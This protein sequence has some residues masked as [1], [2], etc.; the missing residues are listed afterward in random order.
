[1]A[2]TELVGLAD[3]SDFAVAY[4]EASLEL[5]VGL[6]AIGLLQLTRVL[7]YKLVKIH[8]ASWDSLLITR[9]CF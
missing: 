1:V 6:M 5:V 4:T 2:V 7:R 3:D 9:L 8:D